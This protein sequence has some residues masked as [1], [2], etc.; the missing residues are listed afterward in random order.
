MPGE[1][2]PDNRRDF[3]GGFPGD[4][5]N[6][7]EPSGRTPEEQRTYT[8]TRDW[9]AL[10]RAHSAIRRGSLIDLYADA[11][12]YVFARHDPTG[13]VVIAIN[14]GDKPA[15][16]GFSPRAID[17]AGALPRTPPRRR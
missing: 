9:L 17:A 1:G 10:R 13:T 16:V 12:T 5:R 3:P 15:T 7:F 11:D 6:A 4:S 14:R 2:D 8:W